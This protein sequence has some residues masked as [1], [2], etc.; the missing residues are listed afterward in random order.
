ML[1][2]I[3]S[4][5]NSLRIVYDYW[6]S[7][8]DIHIIFIPIHIDVWVANA[9]WLFSSAEVL[10][11]TWNNGKEVPRLDLTSSTTPGQQIHKFDHTRTANPCDWLPCRRAALLLV[12]CPH[13]LVYLHLPVVEGL[14]FCISATPP[15]GNLL[16]IIPWSIFK[17]LYYIDFSCDNVAMQQQTL[18]QN[19]NLTE[20]PRNAKHLRYFWPNISQ[21][22]PRSPPNC[23]W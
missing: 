14:I 15:S 7:I 4:R 18:L 12:G 23:F 11:K 2:S 13:S 9:E 1:L 16:P 17:N 6:T 3:P 20:N 21:M 5:Y 10:A 19:V 22:D 8:F